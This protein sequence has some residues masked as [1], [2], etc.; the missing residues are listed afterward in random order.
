MATTVTEDWAADSI[1][2][3][4]TRRSGNRLM[5]RRTVD[6]K[7]RAVLSQRAATLRNSLILPMNLST[8]LR[9]RHAS[10]SSPR[11]SFRLDFGGMTAV[12]PAAEIMSR[13]ALLSQS[14]SPITVSSGPS[15]SRSAPACVQSAACPGVGS[16]AFTSSFPPMPVRTFAVLPPRLNPTSGGSPSRGAP[17]PCLRT[18]IDEESAMRSRS[19]PLPPSPS[20]PSPS[21]SS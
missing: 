1:D 7:L 15:P 12:A 3:P 5:A 4:A 14:L 17:A 8:G 2:R 6:R 9:S 20:L 21:A 18:R 11:C 16:T 19:S 13:M 10:R